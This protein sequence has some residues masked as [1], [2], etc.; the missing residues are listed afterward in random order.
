[1]SVVHVSYLYTNLNVIGIVVLFLLT[2]S[3]NFLLSPRTYIHTY[4]MILTYIHT[5][6]QAE[7]NMSPLFQSL[8]HTKRYIQHF[9]CFQ[10]H[11][12]LTNNTEAIPSTPSPYAS[13]A[14]YET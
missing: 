8:G 6:G 5:Y 4:I 10:G 7:T 11:S 1:M 2:N 12:R 13:G 3:T 9:G 14:F